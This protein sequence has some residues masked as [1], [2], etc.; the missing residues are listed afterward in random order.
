MAHPPD[1]P[2]TGEDAAA[3]PGGEATKAWVSPD[4]VVPDPATWPSLFRATA[5]VDVH[6]GNAISSVEPLDQRKLRRPAVESP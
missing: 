3:A 5:S 2:G 1:V 6:P 4:A